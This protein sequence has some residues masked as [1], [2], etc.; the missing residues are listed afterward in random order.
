MQ[1]KELKKR[2]MILDLIGVTKSLIQDCKS[3]ILHRKNRADE[4]IAS[5]RREDI[6]NVLKNRFSE[7]TGQ[8]LKIFGI[9]T[10]Y[11]K[12]FA[13]SERDIL[14][15]ITRMPSAEYRLTVENVVYEEPDE[16]MKDSVLEDQD[17]DFE[18]FVI[19][20]RIDLEKYNQEDKLNEEEKIKDS[21]KA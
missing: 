1:D 8:N 12:D 13:T 20:D 16:S 4:E 10:R 17:D 6:I 11:L 7:L 18:D 14:R 5:D 3:F 9:S 19:V 21:G 15:G 2:E